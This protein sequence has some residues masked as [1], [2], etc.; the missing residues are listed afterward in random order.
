MLHL[1]R[2]PNPLL[3][4]H[5]MELWHVE[6]APPRMAERFLP[7]GTLGLVVHLDDNEV[8]IRHGSH[9]QRYTGAVVSGAYR[10]AIGIETR[11]HASRIA[12]TFRPG[13]ARPF[14]GVPPGELADSHVDL[15]SLWGPCVREIR[16]R[17]C[18]AATPSLR[19]EILEHTLLQRLAQAR[20]GH[21]AVPRAIAALEGGRVQVGEVASELGLSH[22]RL[23]DVF[24][25]EV[26]IGP[27]AFARVARFRRTLARARRER[28]PDWS[29]LARTSGYYDQS[30]LVREF[31]AIAGVSPT[32]LLARSTNRAHPLCQ[33][34]CRLG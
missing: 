27:K 19:L 9:E 16:E 14:L 3:A 21:P 4:A 32:S 7:A 13:A 17:L 18:D 10:S 1:R 12:V 8:R 11:P 25:A 30:H 24:T 5:V 15:S 31:N 34:G 33:H 20:A 6:D 2:A 29:T 28:E 23:V 26:G 22:R